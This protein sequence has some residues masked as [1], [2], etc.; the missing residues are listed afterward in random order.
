MAKNNDCRLPQEFATFLGIVPNPTVK[1][2]EGG[3][4]GSSE[5]T[6][7]DVLLGRGAFFDKHPGN[8]QFRKIAAE[9]QKKIGYNSSKKIV[10]T[11]CGAKVVAIVRN[12]TPPGRFLLKTNEG[13][14]E[15]IGDVK[16]RR[17]TLYSINNGIRNKLTPSGRFLPKKYEGYWEE[18]GDVRAR[19]RT[20][21]ALRDGIRNGNYS[22]ESRILKKK[23][24]LAT[25]L[26]HQCHG[27]SN[28]LSGEYMDSLNESNQPL[29]SSKA[30]I[31]NP[32]QNAKSSDVS[33]NF[34]AYEKDHDLSGNSASK[35]NMNSLYL[36][37]KNLRGRPAVGFGPVT[38]HIAPFG[39]LPVFDAVIIGDVTANVAL[40]PHSAPSPF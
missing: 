3:P 31:P 23:K 15:E 8:V 28:S 22:A 18:N 24:H 12:L 27:G 5:I 14:W 16:A 11:F 20:L 13:Y 34:N 33:L 32:N 2:G 19:K 29:D 40:F 25:P 6:N 30:C 26:E 7:N 1:P 9:N 21:Q 35:K 39:R 36:N 10:K 38:D 17:K 4:I 37:W